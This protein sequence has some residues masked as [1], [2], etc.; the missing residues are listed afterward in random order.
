MIIIIADD[1]ITS[2]DISIGF[3]DGG[4]CYM[5][6]LYITQTTIWMR[7]RILLCRTQPIALTCLSLYVGEK[8]IFAVISQ[9]SNLLILCTSWEVDYGRVAW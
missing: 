9:H 8:F 4:C 7:V 6:K 5:Y 3:G 2:I 1:T